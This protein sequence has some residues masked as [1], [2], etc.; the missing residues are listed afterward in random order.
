[1]V[2]YV[3]VLTVINLF[4]NYALLLC[5]AVILKRKISNLRLLL[6]SLVGSAYGLVIFLPSL[7]LPAEILL[8]TVACIVIVLASFGFGNLRRFF[9]CFFVFLAV[10]FS[11]GGIM[12]ALWLTVAPGGMMYNNGTVYFDIGLSTLTV[13]TIIC[14]TVVSLISKFIA[15]RAPVNSVYNLVLHSG[16][17]SL[18]G[19]ALCD[20]G[21]S[22]CESFSGYPV[23]IGEY[24]TLV[25]VLPQSIINYYEKSTVSDDNDNLRII[26]CKT[27][28]EV[29]VLPAFRPDSIEVSSIGKRIVTDEVYVA[30]AK[31]R[32]GG[33]EFDFILNPRI[34]DGENKY[35]DNRKNKKTPAEVQTGID[36][37]LCKRAGN[38][39]R[40][41]VKARG[42]GDNK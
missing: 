31:N 26:M 16:G 23:V 8:R 2:I 21:N 42:A 4:V 36:N 30:V 7:P 19:V 25:A 33:G 34:F 39:A 13:S 40:S 3:D 29:S 15:R 6:G 17:K 28:A 11:F 27:V 10:S 12:L 38:S 32:I 14:F 22:L 9:R 1:M 5:S 24:D 35:E 37:T 20:T 41:A 18:S